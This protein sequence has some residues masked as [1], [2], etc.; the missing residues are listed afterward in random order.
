[1]WDICHVRYN[2]PMSNKCELPGLSEVFYSQN[3]PESSSW[4]VDGLLEEAIEWLLKKY[5]KK[6]KK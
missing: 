5:E 1:M 3:K 4:A 2:R 6:D